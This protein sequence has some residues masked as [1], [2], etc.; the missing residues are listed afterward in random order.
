MKRYNGN[1]HNYV[2]DRKNT[3]RARVE[4][5]QKS[6]KQEAER[7]KEKI[8]KYGNNP[9][10]ILIGEK[11]RINGLQ[12]QQIADEALKISYNYGYYERGSRVL[13]GLFLDGIYTEEEQKKIGILDVINGVSDKYIDNLKDYKAYINGRIYQKGREAFTFIEENNISFEEYVSMMEILFPEVNEPAFKEGYYSKK[14]ENENN[15]NKKR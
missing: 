13:E 9:Q 14:I 2:R 3:A 15:H 11:D 4:N 5:K 12:P 6:L 10:L 8:E 7:K 1:N